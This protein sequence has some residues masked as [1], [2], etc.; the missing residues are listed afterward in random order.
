MPRNGT[1]EVSSHV[2]SVA[3][4]G[5]CSRFGHNGEAPC[6]NFNASWKC[7]SY[8][9]GFKKLQLLQCFNLIVH[10]MVSEIPYHGNYCARGGFWNPIAPRRFQKCHNTK[11]LR[12][13]RFQKFHV[14]ENIA[15]KAVSKF[16]K[17]QKF[18]ITEII[19]PEVISEIP[20]HGKYHARSGFWNSMSRKSLR[21]RRFQKF[22]ITEL[23]RLRGFQKFHIAENF[24]SGR[25]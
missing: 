22:H 12:P 14:T 20:S 1:V 17:F 8:A 2:R 21:P 16:P 15:P 5:F 6:A 3:I 25:F 10:E 18:Q 11:L 24:P 19:A 13:R 23:L 7:K 9:D 4:P